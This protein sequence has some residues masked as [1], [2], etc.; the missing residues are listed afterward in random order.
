MRWLCGLETPY[1]FLFLQPHGCFKAWSS[2]E[3]PFLSSS[4]RNAVEAKDKDILDRGVVMKQAH[5]QRISIVVS[6][7]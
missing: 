3:I 7:Q 2:S 4:I 5:M 1:V 6:E